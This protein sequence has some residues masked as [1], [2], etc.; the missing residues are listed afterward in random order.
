MNNFDKQQHTL[1]EK[2]KKC[3]VPD[4]QCL[5]KYSVIKFN[6]FMLA[7]KFKWILEKYTHTSNL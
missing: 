4:V 1:K 2:R 7:N 5:I 3:N 6:S